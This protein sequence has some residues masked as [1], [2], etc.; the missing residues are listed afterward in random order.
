M[1]HALILM[2]VVFPVLT[3]CDGFRSAG[4]GL[5]VPDIPENARQE[6]QSPTAFLRAGDWELVAGRMGDELIRCEG[7]REIAV[8]GFDAVR[9]AVSGD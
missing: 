5:E 2:F 4:E 9:D 3:A 7:R 1:R 6:C 8:Q